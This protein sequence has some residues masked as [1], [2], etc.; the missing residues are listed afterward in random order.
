MNEW[1]SEHWCNDTDRENM[2]Y[3]DKNL[4]QCQDTSST[5]NL[6]CSGIK[7]RLSKAAYY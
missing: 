6:T 4:S 5:K 3:W 2:K 7:P 1:S